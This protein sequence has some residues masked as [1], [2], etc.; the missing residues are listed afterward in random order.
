MQAYY[1]YKV[2][3]IWKTGPTNALPEHLCIVRAH[4]NL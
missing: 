2:T 1:D 4:V 3:L